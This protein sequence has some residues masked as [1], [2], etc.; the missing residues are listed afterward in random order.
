MNRC[1]HYVQDS[2]T[3]MEDFIEVFQ[4][5]LVSHQNTDIHPVHDFLGVKA[6][7]VLADSS[8]GLSKFVQFVQHFFA[9]GKE[10]FIW[11]EDCSLI[12]LVDGGQEFREVEALDSHSV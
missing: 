12:N 7:K 2:Y 5:G 11:Q 8:I 6:L 9:K 1:R 10:G 4:G 3:E